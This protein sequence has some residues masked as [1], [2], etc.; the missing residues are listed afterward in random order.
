MSLEAVLTVGWPEVPA[1]DQHSAKAI[2]KACQSGD[3][4]TRDKQYHQKLLAILN[5]LRQTLDGRQPLIIKG[6]ESLFRRRANGFAAIK[7]F[8]GTLNEVDVFRPVFETVQCE[9]DVFAYA[10]LKKAKNFDFFLPETQEKKGSFRALYPQWRQEMAD[11][12][13]F[14]RRGKHAS[15]IDVNGYLQLR[16]I[17]ARKT[18]RDERRVLATLLVSGPSP[19]EEIR[20][21]LGLPYNLA[22]RILPTLQNID[23][24]DIRNQN[25]YVIDIAVL[26]RVLFCLREVMGLDLLS[27]LD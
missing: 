4:S 16:R 18:A 5:E 20:E 11:L 10:F 9:I 21:D 8:A 17:I 25:C 7:Q 15:R 2:H 23:V 22:E 1:N 3:E 13:A 27:A 24:L 12:E 26:P 6:M 19:R 14:E